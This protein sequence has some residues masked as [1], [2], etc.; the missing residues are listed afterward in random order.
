MTSERILDGALTALALLPPAL[1]LVAAIDHGEVT[2]VRVGVLLALLA[3]LHGAP[4]WWR[5]VAPWPALAAVLGA[6]LAHATIV[7]AAGLPVAASWPL[8]AGLC[9]EV[10]TVWAVATYARPTVATWAAALATGGVW[11]LVIQ[12]MGDE[13]IVYASDY[14]H[15]DCAFPDTVKLIA[16]RNDISDAS[17]RRIL[18]ENAKSMYALV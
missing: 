11:S 12:L 18:G 15:W 3:L 6:A 5:R 9:A 7:A 13:K 17:K 4:V 2:D 1:V 16:E 14:Y 8:F 10:I